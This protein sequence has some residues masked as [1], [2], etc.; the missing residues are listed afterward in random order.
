LIEELW[1]FARF[2]RTLY[3]PRECLSRWSPFDQA[4][5]QGYAI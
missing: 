1:G 2:M 4:P 5:Q 3:A